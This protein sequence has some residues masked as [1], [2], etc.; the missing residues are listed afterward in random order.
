MHVNIALQALLDSG[1]KQQD[2]ADALGVSQA[3]VSRWLRGQDP[4]GSTRDA[5]FEL[6]HQK[7]VLGNEKGLPRTQP[8]AIVGPKVVY[9]GASPTIPIYGQAMGGLDGRFVLNGTKIA[10]IPT[11]H[12]LAGVPDA[13]AVY[14]VGD[15]MEPRYFAGET[16]YVHPHMPVRKGDFVVVQFH[17]E[18][19]AEGDPPFAYVKQLV[20]FDHKRLKL[21]QLHP[22]KELELPAARVVSIHKI[23]GSSL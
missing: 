23:V 9:D 4:Q 14:I 20:A 5:I 15:S 17:P 7:N 21:S 2:V 16:A 3:T 19:A 10:D 11:P 18:D 6:A 8:N 12:A 13:Y 1:M 22:E